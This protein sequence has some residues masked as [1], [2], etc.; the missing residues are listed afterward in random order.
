[1]KPPCKNCKIRHEGCHSKCVDYLDYRAKKDK[2]NA[3]LR[4]EPA[5]DLLIKGACKCAER[6]KR[7]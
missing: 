6:K 5:D 2:L 1:M 4:A 3:W 7:K